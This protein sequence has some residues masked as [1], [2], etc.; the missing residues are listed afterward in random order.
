[1]IT[2][3]LVSL[4]IGIITCSQ[5]DEMELAAIPNQPTE[6]PKGQLSIFIKIPSRTLE[7]HEN[8][9]VY[10]TYRI[11]VGKSE[12]PSPVGEWVVI[13]KSYR[14]GDIFGTRFLALNVPWGGYGIHGTNQP[15]SIGNYASHGCIRM[16]NKDIE[17]LYEWVPVGT[18]V[19]IESHPV[20]IQRQLKINL[21]GPDVVKL[22]V[23]LRNI[24]YLEERADGFF[25]KETEIAVKRF[26]YDN[27]LKTTGVVDKKTLNL[28]GL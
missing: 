22:Q 5:W 6:A 25:N 14:A 3:L 1:M 2:V 18:P 28:L 4:F 26:Q 19:R 8:N 9:K 11:A 23:R 27:G 15:W 12:T 7:I 13:W 17:E 20:S 10:K 21:M 16:R 24:G